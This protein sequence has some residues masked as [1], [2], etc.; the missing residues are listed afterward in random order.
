M[1]IKFTCCAT[2]SQSSVMDNK[3]EFAQRLREAMVA[4]GLEPR[5]GVLL[6]LFNTR[7]WGRS[8]SF[9]AVSRWLRGQAI[10]EQDKLLV[11]AEIVNVPPE[12]LRFG[13]TVRQAIQQRQA[14]WDQG[15]GYLERETFDAFLQLPVSQRKLI[16]ETILLFRKANSTEATDG[17][18]G[19]AAQAA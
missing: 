4:A 14:R 13:A 10:P 5:P 9:Q 8:V 3:L 17:H 1:N 16:R 11:L 15:A 2:E 6:N 18:T 7:Y 12:V 19:A